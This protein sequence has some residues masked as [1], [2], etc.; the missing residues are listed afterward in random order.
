[1]MQTVNKMELSFPSRSVNEAF[2]RGAVTA[3]SLI[4]I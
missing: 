1:M 4:H 2:A 3:L